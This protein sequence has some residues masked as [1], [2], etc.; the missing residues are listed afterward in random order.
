MQTDEDR[1][2]LTGLI[3]LV[4]V[5]LVVGV[6][7]GAAA[8]V[9]TK[10]LG[11]GGDDVSS[12]EATSGESM[13]LPRPQKTESADGPL[14][15]LSPT[16][17]TASGSASASPSD[18]PTKSKPPKKKKKISLAAAQTTVP[19][20]GRID[21]TGVYPQGEGAIL[22][23]QRFE[24]KWDDFGVTISVSNGTFATYIQTGRSGVNRFRV[25]DT[26]TG[27]PSNEVRVT[28]G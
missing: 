25:V 20:M 2:I 13:Y 9:G 1:P 4:A 27:V 14:I 5:A 3:A 12:A 24:G 21:L 10:I 16:G 28:I 18:S 11:V 15:T 23:V 7:L 6:V 17:G 19:S 26:D 8:L 22:M